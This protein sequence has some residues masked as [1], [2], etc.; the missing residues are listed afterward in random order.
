MVQHDATTRVAVLTALLT[1]I[2]ADAI[3]ELYNS[4]NSVLATFIGVNFTQTGVSAVLD[5][6][7][8]VNADLDG[9]VARSRL[10]NQARTRYQEIVNPTNTQIQLSTFFLSAG[11]PVTL[12]GYTIGAPQ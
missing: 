1:E 4:S 12:T 2:G 9:E 3:L 11:V 10:Y 6:S 7:I 5:A 8:S